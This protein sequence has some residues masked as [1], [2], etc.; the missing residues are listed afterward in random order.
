[1]TEHVNRIT[2]DKGTRVEIGKIGTMCPGG[3]V[4]V[5]SEYLALPGPAV[6]VVFG[7][8]QLFHCG[9]AQ[10]QCGDQASAGTPGKTGTVTVNPVRIGRFVEDRVLL[11]ERTYHK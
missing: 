7:A 3:A 10:I 1:M 5:G 6:S 9:A 4:V 8:G 2:R 11:C